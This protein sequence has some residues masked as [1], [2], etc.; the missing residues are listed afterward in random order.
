MTAGVMPCRQRLGV[1]S[2]RFTKGHV[3][4]L[5]FCRPSY[6]CSKA[7]SEK[8][9]PTLAGEQE[10][11][12]TLVT[13]K[14]SAEVFATAFGQRVAADDELLLLGQFHLDPRTTAATGL[15]KRVR[16]YWRSSPK[17]PRAKRLLAI[18]WKVTSV[19]VFVSLTAALTSQL[20]LKHLRGPV[21][22]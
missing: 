12:P 2:G 7:F 14:Q 3:G 16:L 5:I 4:R 22:R 9:V 17:A 10:T 6:R 8:R 18:V 19:I 13:D 15:A 11:V 1:F 20:T 21:K